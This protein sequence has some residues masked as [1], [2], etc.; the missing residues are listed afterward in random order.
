M[1]NSKLKEDLACAIASIKN[2]REEVVIL[3]RL[4]SYRTSSEVVRTHR[5]YGF[6][7]PVHG[8]YKSHIKVGN[9]EISTLRSPKTSES[10]ET[11]TVIGKVKK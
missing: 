8:N 3:K 6:D 9:I 1:F 4:L 11:T 10:Y 7:C 5:D 2:L